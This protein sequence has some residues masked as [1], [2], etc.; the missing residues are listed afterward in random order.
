MN[1]LSIN[2]YYNKNY[3]HV[4]SEQYKAIYLPKL[5]RSNITSVL[6]F[7]INTR[8]KHKFRFS[9]VFPVLVLLMCVAVSI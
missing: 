6:L 7:E 3:E 8:N 9:I 4:Y 5:R 2:E 1:L